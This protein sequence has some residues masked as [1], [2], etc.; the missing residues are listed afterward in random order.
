[1]T[2]FLKKIRINQKGTALLVALLVMG[3]LISISL[4]LSTLILRESLSIRELID[5]GKAYYAAESG[6]EE[7]LY[8]LDSRLPGWEG[9]ENNLGAVSD[10]A[11]FSY[12]VKNK[13]N[14]YPCFDEDEYNL[15]LMQAYNYYDVLDLNE[16][17]TVP[18][19]IVDNEGQVKAAKDFTVEFFTKFNPWTDLKFQ[20][21]SDLSGWDVLRWKLFGL[22]QTENG[23][24]TEALHDFTAVS[25][26][27][28]TAT[29][30][31]FSTNAN[32]P[33][34]FGSKACTPAS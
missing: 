28:N 12:V 18:L 3:V 5:A 4:A 2:K 17:I 1:M 11:T 24:A 9:N 30:E 15:D 29:G 32:V 25:A 20:N 14:S 19:F 21:A 13:C 6:I 26:A 23:Y 16:S 33:S 10:K 27:K 7:A 8:Y 31:T 34:W 22:K